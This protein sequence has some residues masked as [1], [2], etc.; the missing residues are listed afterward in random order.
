MNS[1]GTEDAYYA[2][3]AL[4]NPQLSW[5]RDMP[6]FWENYF[7]EAIEDLFCQG[8]AARRGSKYA[9]SLC[10]PP[11]KMSQRANKK[12]DAR[13]RPSARDQIRRSRILAIQ[14]AIE[15]FT[16]FAYSPGVSEATP[17]IAQQGNDVVFTKMREGDHLASDFYRAGSGGA[18]R[19]C[20]DVA[21]ALA[22]L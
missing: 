4:H 18:G 20:T 16:H 6:D 21:L 9:R 1:R 19:D 12:A 17:L 11:C 13:R 8:R 5:T 14:G 3:N 2:E 10:S 7:Q 22:S 15:I